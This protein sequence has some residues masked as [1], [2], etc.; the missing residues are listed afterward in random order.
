[1]PPSWSDRSSGVRLSG[2]EPGAAGS[3]ERHSQAAGLQTTRG[4]TVAGEAPRSWD[5]AWERPDGSGVQQSEVQAS[6]RPAQ[7]EAAESPALGQA[8]PAWALPA[9]AKKAPQAAAKATM[10][11]RRR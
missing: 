11:R 9:N 1:M 10:E 6:G 2:L 5:R 8:M 3:L 7:H 4:A